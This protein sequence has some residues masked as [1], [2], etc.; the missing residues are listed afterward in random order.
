LQQECHNSKF[1][2]FEILVYKETFAGA[3]FNRSS[4]I[5]QFAKLAAGEQL[6]R[7]LHSQKFIAL[8]KPLNVSPEKLQI[9]SCDT[10][11]ANGR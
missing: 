6:G 7:L 3:L 4:V 2:S 1:G 11:V 10:V 5:T 9:L 8:Q